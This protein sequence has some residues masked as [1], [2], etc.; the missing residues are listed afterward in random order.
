MLRIS[1]VWRIRQMDFCAKVLV[2]ASMTRTLHKNPLGSEQLQLIKK[3]AI[4]WRKL[5]VFLSGFGL[6]RILKISIL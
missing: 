1:S 5:P 2:H 6:K 4:F 3:Q